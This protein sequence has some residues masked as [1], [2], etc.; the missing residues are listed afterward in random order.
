MIILYFSYL[1]LSCNLCNIHHITTGCIYSM[2]IG[3]SGRIVLEVDPELK[4]ELYSQLVKDGMQL[5]QWFLSC[6]TQYI[7]EKAQETE[8]HK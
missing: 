1:D 6:A 4:K 5:K 8:K 7:E 3:N 2:S